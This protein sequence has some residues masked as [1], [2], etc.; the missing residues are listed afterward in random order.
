MRRDPKSLRRIGDERTL[1]A[2]LQGDDL[3]H[4][5][6]ID[7]F[8]DPERAQKPAVGI[9]AE[10]GEVACAGALARC[11]DREVR[12]VAAEALQPEATFA[13][14]GPVELDHRL[15]KGGQFAPRGHICLH[16]LHAGA[17]DFAFRAARRS[18][19]E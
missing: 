8:P 3:S 2:Q 13:L 19:D 11:G 5:A 9:V 7:T 15:A 18:S 1:G 12:G 17:P 10:G 4:A 6:R 16:G 14:A